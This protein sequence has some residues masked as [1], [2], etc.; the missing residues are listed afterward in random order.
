[1]YVPELYRPPNQAALH[2]VIVGNP[3]GLLVTTTGA[4][5]AGVHILDRTGFVGGRGFW[6]G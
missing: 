5:L 4:G 1:V 2:E 3:F 6:E